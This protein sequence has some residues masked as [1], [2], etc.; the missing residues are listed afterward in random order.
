MNVAKLFKDI[1][2]AEKTAAAKPAQN[3]AAAA[4]ESA[5]D[6]EKVAMEKIAED[7]VIAGGM[8]AD[9][10]VDR[11]IETLPTKLAAFV[12]TGSVGRND[13]RKGHSGLDAEGST[14]ARISK[15]IQRDRGAASID[16][17]SGHT[18]AEHAYPR[19]IGKKT[20]PKGPGY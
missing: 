8:M 7:L 6:A 3:S 4:P 11:V 15:K 18:R 2:D 10:L 9:A 5:D 19:R 20:L 17:D 12:G 14:W 16:E 13:S 1:Q